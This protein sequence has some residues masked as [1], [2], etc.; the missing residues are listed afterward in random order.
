MLEMDLL[1]VLVAV[2]IALTADVLNTDLFPNIS[3]QIGFPSYSCTLKSARIVK[4]WSKLQ[5]LAGL[6]TSVRISLMRT[7]PRL[8]IASL[9]LQHCDVMHI[10]VKL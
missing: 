2:S 3:L 5:S 6:E 8:S 10:D 7:S 1:I 4:T 9:L